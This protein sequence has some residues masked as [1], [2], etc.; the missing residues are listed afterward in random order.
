[1]ARYTRVF[2]DCDDTVLDFGASEH[3]ALHE[4]M[5]LLGLPFPEEAERYYRAVNAALWKQYEQGGIAQAAL[6]VERFR[7][8]LTHLGHG[9]DIAE[10]LN[11]A[12]AEALSHSS[13]L[14][15]GA[16]EFCRRA[17]QRFP[18]YML[19]NGVAFIQDRRIAASPAREYLSGVFISERLGWQKP[20]KEFF[21]AVF[22]ALGMGDEDIRHAVMIGD[23]LHSDISGGQNAGM[24]TVWLNL[25]GKAGDENIRPTYTARNFDEICQLLGC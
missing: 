17:A 25:N 21:R 3:A 1:M 14:L 5:A 7:R 16:L 23:S 6:C 2:L 12:Y 9:P 22:D 15:P 24:D 8:L 10:A 11:D 13:I 19:T 4:A 18:L 20:Q